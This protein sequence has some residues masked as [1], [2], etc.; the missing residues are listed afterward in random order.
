MRPLRFLALALALA[1]TS[2]LAAQFIQ[3]LPAP[4]DADALAD[5]VRALAANPQDLNAL[6]RAGELTLK[7]DDATAAASFFARAERIDPRNARIKAGLGVLLVQAE[8]PGEALRRFSEA[9]GY[10]GR[11]ASFAADRGLAFDLIG[12]QERAQRDYRLA[13][14]NGPNDETTRRY[15]LSLGISGKRD[16][17]LALLDP[18]LRKSDRGAWR[19]RAFIL[20]MSG[21]KADAEKIATTMMPAGLSQGLQP[22]FDRLAALS[23]V[24]RAFAVHFGEI[25]PSPVRIADARLVPA[26][27]PLGPD[28]DAVELAAAA[29]AREKPVRVE[30]AQ[31]V[32]KR[33]RNRREPVQL[34]V[35]AAPLPV[36]PALPAPPAYVDPG[37]AARGTAAT[38]NGY[39][40][41]PLPTP[42]PYT[43]SPYTPSPYRPNTYTQNSYA[44]NT[45][46]PGNNAVAQ[47][48]RASAA[49]TPTAPATETRAVAALPM[50]APQTQSYQPV[51]PTGG[52]VMPLAPLQPQPLPSATVPSRAPVPTYAPATPPPETTTRI[53]TAPAPV[54]SAP[55]VTTPA[56]VAVQPTPAT[57]IPP[58]SIPA[59][60]TPTVPTSAPGLVART[61]PVAPTNVAKVQ[62][63]DAILSG[64]IA[65]VGVPGAELGVAPIVKPAPAPIVAAEPV[66]AAPVEIAKVEPARK[67]PEVPP[68]DEK[69]AAKKKADAKAAE[70]KLAAETKKAADAKKLADAKK[71][72]DAKK[73]AE[74][75]KLAEAKKKDPKFLEPSRVWV[76]VSGGANEQDLPKQWNKLRGDKSSVFKGRQGW[77]TPLRATNR[78]LTGPFASEAEAQTFVNKLAKEGLSGFLFTSEAG[79]KIS[80][81]PAK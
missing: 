43:P 68:I 16:E 11:V 48:N 66:R 45:Y 4:G 65:K 50:R 35:Q 47:A 30:A 1:S 25:R 13:L 67:K 54:A 17:A 78:I 42:R 59:T 36:A 58:A 24:D 2:P 60:P 40:V 79:Q 62:S 76:Q 20:A 61:A 38:Q 53:E 57:S 3:P 29:K 34:A 63:E 26:L 9:E 5:Q 71:A 80:K 10:G 46:T 51:Q 69:A 27:P 39:Y 72:A 19:A 32:K 37:T 33:K 31:P 41:Q 22:F 15:A 64:I 12:E 55:V 6:I 23:P 74:A 28:P 75:K 14:K 8:R 70:A 7:L 77:S 21:E 49:A 56:P 18:L 44:R 81:L 52:R 73:G